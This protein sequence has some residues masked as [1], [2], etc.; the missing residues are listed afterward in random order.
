MGCGGRTNSHMARDSWPVSTRPVA[1]VTGATAGIGEAIARRL[2]SRDHEVIATGRNEQALDALRA[3]GLCA[4]NLDV[5]DHGAVAA[6]VEE[7]DTRFGGVDV[8]VNNAGLGFASPL[9]Q[10]AMGDLRRILETNVVAMLNLCQTVLPGMRSRRA[11]TIVNIGST[12]GRFTTPGAGAYHISKYG[13]EALS[14]ALRAEVERFGVRV[15]LIEPTGVRT[16]FAQSQLGAT[17]IDEGDDPYGEFKRRYAEI[18]AELAK[19]PLVSV[20]ADKVA[21]VVVRAIEAKRPRAR[22]VV[23]MSGKASVIAHCLLTDRMW[24]RVLLKRLNPTS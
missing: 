5:T 13:V 18:T 19:T 10:A 6:L 16:T 12:G 20:S 4:R 22:Y 2:Q 21:R 14:D 11:G 24:D 15:I 9:E 8:L 7:I 1:L 23:G 17:P 3:R